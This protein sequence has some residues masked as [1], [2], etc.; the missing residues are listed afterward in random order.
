[1]QTCRDCQTEVSWSAKTC[2]KCGAKDP[3]VGKVGY[4]FMQFVA[5][6]G[7]LAVGWFIWTSCDP[8]PVLDSLSEINEPSV[9][10]ATTRLSRAERCQQRA[11][12]V[13]EGMDRIDQF[14]QT[15][16]IR[17]EAGRWDSAQSSYDMFHSQVEASLLSAE[18]LLDECGDL[19]P[20]SVDALRSEL[21]NIRDLADESRR[22]CHR[23]MPAD[24]D[25]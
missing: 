25:C 19:A 3:T 16:A 8:G 15:T 7:A 2:P 5:V 9:T 4:G 12:R 24:F 22:V 10:V 1:M 6:A 23:E 18:A 13:A 20:D 17:L 21:D 14:A 11:S